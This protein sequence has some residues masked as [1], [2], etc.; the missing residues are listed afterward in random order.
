MGKHSFANSSF[1][2]IAMNL[3]SRCLYEQVC[4]DGNSGSP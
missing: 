1:V 2:F 4:P 3:F